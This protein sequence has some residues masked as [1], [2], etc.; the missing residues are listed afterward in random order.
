M[1]TYLLSFVTSDFSKD[2]KIWSTEAI[3]LY[4][5]KY[6]KNYSYTRSPTGI[7]SL[8]DYTFTGIKNI[9]GATPTI[10]GASQVTDIRRS[11]PRTRVSNI[12]HL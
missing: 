9:N 10:S 4:A 12:L 6:Y 2:G 8:G 11:I 1:K 3:D 5:N 7:N